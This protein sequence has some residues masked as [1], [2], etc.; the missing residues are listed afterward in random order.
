MLLLIYVQLIST[1]LFYSCKIQTSAWFR[2]V[3]SDNLDGDN[4]R[5]EQRFWKLRKNKYLPTDTSTLAEIILLWK[6]FII[7]IEDK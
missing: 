3:I 4:K 7:V 6:H 2:S 5:I 1:S